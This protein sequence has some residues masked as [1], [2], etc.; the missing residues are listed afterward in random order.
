MIG[1]IETE[2]QCIV[3]VF[4]IQYISSKYKIYTCQEL[5]KENIVPTLG[6]KYMITIPILGSIMMIVMFFK[7]Q[8]IGYILR[9]VFIFYIWYSL[10]SMSTPIIDYIPLTNK[11]HSTVKLIIRLFLSISI[12]IICM[13]NLNWITINIISIVLIIS[14]QSF[15]FFEK[16]NVPIVLNIVMLI[17]DFFWVFQSKKIPIFEGKSVME[18][19]AMTS[20]KQKLSM[21]L[22]FKSF[23]DP[24]QVSL[25][26][27]GDIGL[28]GAFS[29]TCVCIDRFLHT[30]YFM[31][32]TIGHLSGIVIASIC[33]NVFKA[34]QP[35]LI[36][37][38]PCMIG[39]FII[40][41]VRS[42]TLNK[43]FRINIKEEFEKESKQNEVFEVNDIELDVNNNNDININVNN[44]DNDNELNNTIEMVDN[45]REIIQNVHE[46]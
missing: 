46:D 38:V 24:N 36:Y 17:Y 18:E 35:A 13:T 21:L 39:M 37:I 27:L 40:H 11:L 8:L 44:N 16:V 42:K 5:V 22:T 41:A 1:L 20:I 28:P 34:G 45:E 6:W 2:I 23:L 10:F 30:K 32:T 31:Y 29:M 33:A 12:T 19:N 9:I 3:L 26:G 4:L 43:V 7:P 25:L 15:L 14:M